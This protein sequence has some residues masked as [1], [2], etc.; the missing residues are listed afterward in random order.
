MFY[1]NQEIED[2]VVSYDYN[3]DYADIK[4]INNIKEELNIVINNSD[5]LAY[6][7]YKYDYIK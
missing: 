1:K 5:V 6:F 4:I 3:D 2:V 7:L